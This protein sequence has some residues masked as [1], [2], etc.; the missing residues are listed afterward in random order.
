MT[1]REKELL[2]QALNALE[3]L[4]RIF[5]VERILYLVA[6][7]ASSGLFIFAGYRL[8]SQDVVRTEDMVIIL[9]ATGVSTACSTRLALYLNK[10]PSFIK[11][12]KK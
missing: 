10:L 8:F 3:R 5:V 1:E 7:V 6:G 9:G 11:P 12:A 4:M 2:E